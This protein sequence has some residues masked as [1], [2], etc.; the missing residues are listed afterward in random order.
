M[1]RFISALITVLFVTAFANDLTAEDLS[2]AKRADIAKLM[3]ITGALALG[4]QMSDAMVAQMTQM[5]KTSRP[6]LDPKWF[7]LLQKEVNSVVEE[8]LPKFVE[9]M[10]PIYHKYFT[11][12]DIEGMLKF[13]QTPLGQKAVRVMPDLLQESMYMGKQWG[14][15]LGPEILRRVIERFKKEGVDLQASRTDAIRIAGLP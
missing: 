10:I 4:K 1:K 12:D 7:D 5:V 13:Y 15:A 6:D 8:S 2:E 14:Q 9:I 11:H 3:Q